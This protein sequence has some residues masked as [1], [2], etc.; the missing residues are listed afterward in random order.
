MMNK[1]EACKLLLTTN[2]QCSISSVISIIKVLIYGIIRVY[3]RR[4]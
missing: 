1:Q 2:G 3:N 4:F